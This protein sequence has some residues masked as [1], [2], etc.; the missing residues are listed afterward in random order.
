M[1]RPG[2]AGTPAASGGAPEDYR[3][4]PV[5]ADPPNLAKPGITEIRRRP[6]IPAWVRSKADL[7]SALTRAGMNAGYACGF[8]CVRAPYYA[9][10]LATTAPFGAARFVKSANRWVWDLDMA[11]LRAAAVKAD[12]ASEYMTLTRA[13]DRHVRWRSLVAAVASV[14]G[15]GLALSMYVLAPGYLFAMAG[16]AVLALGYA[17]QRPDKPI[18][19]P[20]VVKTELEKLTASIVLR[21]LGVDRQ[22]LDQ[23][24]P[25]Q[26]RG[27]YPLHLGDHP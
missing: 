25:G 24:G 4:L 10:R 26:G 27:G 17:G 13:R 14:F 9:A 8:H 1:S 5:P 22:R 20:A 15:L 2:P 23:Q 18:I 12:N 3:P 7:T 11:P 6:I 16:A 21:A 19:G